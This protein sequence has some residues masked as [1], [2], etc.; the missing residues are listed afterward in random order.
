MGKCATLLDRIHLQKYTY[1]LSL[2]VLRK[3]TAAEFETIF[4]KVRRE[5]NYLS[6]GS[7]EESIEKILGTFFLD[8]DEYAT[9]DLYDPNDPYNIDEE[10]FYI[11]AES[12]LKKLNGYLN[13]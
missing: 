9:D 4:L 8:V 11:R 6:S 12:T 1:M 7:F 3:I 2:L 10:E 5:D 13:A